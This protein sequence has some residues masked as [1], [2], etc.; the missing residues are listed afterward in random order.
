[1]SLLLLFCSGP[2][3]ETLDEQAINEYE[4]ELDTL[5]NQIRKIPGKK[6]P[7]EFITLYIQIQQILDILP[8]TSNLQD[9]TRLELIPRLDQVGAYEEAIKQ[10]WEYLDRVELK[11]TNTE[12]DGLEIYGLLAGMYNAIGNSDSAYIVYQL[13]IQKS[14]H[15]PDELRVSTSLN[16][17]GLYFNNLEK[18]DSALIHLI[19]ADSVLTAHPDKSDYWKKFHGTVRNNMANIYIDLGEYEKAKILYQEMFD[20]YKNLGPEMGE[21]YS[22]I[23]LV[24]AN[25]G[26][27]ICKEQEEFLNAMSFKLDPLEFSQK[28]DFNLYLWE[29][30]TNLYQCIGDINNAFFYQQKSMH[31]KDSLSKR[32]E[33]AIVQ[34]NSQLSNFTSEHFKHQLQIEKAEH[35]KDKQTARLRLWI[36]MLMT[37]GAILTPISFYYYYKQRLRLQAE[38]SER[39]KTNRLLSEEKVKTNEQEKRLVEIELENKKKDLADMAIS[40]SQKQEWASELNQHLQ[41]IESSKGSKRSREF[42]KL[43]ESV[44]EQIYVSKQTDLLRENINALSV[45]YYEEL[46]EKFP[47]LTK[48]EIKLCSFIRL[49][50]TISQI[51]HLQHIDSSSVVVGR[52]RLK[53]KLE[54]GT[55]QNLD[56]FLQTL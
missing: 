1:M 19:L 25:I 42:M 16:N 49:K 9:A 10:S 18:Y 15:H 37:L 52:Y 30:Y 56:E 32:K 34:S 36:I 46:R 43:K 20:F 23:S 54:L 51:A 12:K 3:S 50:L 39:H 2:I 11:N 24:N 41:I 22:G 33:I 13:A 53:R 38:R 29:V 8:D 47:S 21:V 45:G 28:L 35:E 14:K 48:T 55:D 5:L 26:L 6:R 31:M 27:G 4:I 44:R 40:L 17:M 7:T